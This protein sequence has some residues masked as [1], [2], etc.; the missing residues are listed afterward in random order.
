MFF[1]KHAANIICVAVANHCPNASAVRCD[2]S[3]NDSAR[4]SLML[5]PFKWNVFRLRATE[6]WWAGAMRPFVKLLWPLV[7]ILLLY[8]EF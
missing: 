1:A 3:T 4:E 7:N 6:H 2:A 5:K 8:N